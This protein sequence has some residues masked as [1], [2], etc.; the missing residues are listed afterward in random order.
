MGHFNR[1]SIWL[2]FVSFPSFVAPPPFLLL[3]SFF[4]CLLG[5]GPHTCCI[6]DTLFMSPS[7][8]LPITCVIVSS[9][10]PPSRPALHSKPLSVSDDSS[11]NPIREARAVGVGGR[12]RGRHRLLHHSCLLGARVRNLPAT[13]KYSAPDALDFFWSCVL[14]LLVQ[15]KYS[16]VPV[17]K[18]HVSIFQLERPIQN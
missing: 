4:C 7:H 5:L 8:Q 18:Y 14:I 11:S 6:Q 12:V 1:R 9:G 16:L 3:L 17:E 15:K 13:A 10:V 2:G